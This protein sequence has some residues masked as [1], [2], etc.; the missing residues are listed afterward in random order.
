MNEYLIIAKHCLSIGVGYAALYFILLFNVTFMQQKYSTRMYIVKNFLK[1]L[2]LFYISINL[3]YELLNNYIEGNLILDNLFIKNYGSL[4][5]SNDIVALIVVRRLPIT[6]KIHHT[7]T[8]LLL[9]Y[10]FTLDINDYN[11]IGIM[12]LIYSLFSAYAFMVNF[13]LAARYFRVEDKNYVTKYI[14]KN[15]YIDNIRYWSYYIYI[16]LCSINW[17]VNVIIYILKIYYNTLNLEYVLYVIVI[18][19]IVKDDLILMDWLKS[20]SKIV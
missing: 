19:M 7:L 12:I 18:S 13:Y 16:G 10:F 5:V 20:K 9:L 15:R 11:N 4:Y 17:S 8:T 2:I 6:T 1:S 14:N 3:T